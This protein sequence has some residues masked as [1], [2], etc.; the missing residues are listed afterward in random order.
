[1][2][3]DLS[4]DDEEETSSTARLLANLGSSFLYLRSKAVN[5]IKN[6]FLNISS[7]GDVKQG[8]FKRLGRAIMSAFIERQHCEKPFRAALVEAITAALTG[9]YLP[10]DFADF[11]AEYLNESKAKWLHSSS[12]A[13]AIELCI[14]VLTVKKMPDTDINAQTSLEQS[15]DKTRQDKIG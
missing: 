6:L 9:S 8:P 1:M 4:P 15:Q 5:D 14:L 11:A 12:K 3:S 7:E 2:S 13:S 10:F